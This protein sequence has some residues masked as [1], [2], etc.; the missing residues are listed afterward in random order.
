MFEFENLWI[1][2]SGQSRQDI[3]DFWDANKLLKPGVKGEDRVKEAVLAV[4]NELGKVIGVSTAFKAHFKQ[5]NNN[6][7]VFRC[8]IAA[9]SRAP[10]LMSKIIVETRDFLESVYKKDP[11]PCVGLI[12]FVENPIINK[13]RREAV[14]PA[15]KMVYIGETP[16]GKQ[17][18]V[19]YFK[20]ARI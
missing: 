1:S 2:Q 14:W 4:R 8:A 15:S 10:G 9:D 18:R 20:G 7:Y 16:D 19:Y 11:E 13:N 12:T 5:L 6:F 3:I 17:I